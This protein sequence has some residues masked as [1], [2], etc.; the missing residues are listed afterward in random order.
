VAKKMKR[1]RLTKAQIKANIKRYG[2]PPIYVI[3]AQREDGTWYSPWGDSFTKKEGMARLK[4]IQS[5]YLGKTD[6][7]RLTKRKRI[8]YGSRGLQERYGFE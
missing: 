1:H 8:P 6:N 5:S 2:P 4:E 3:E 7:Y